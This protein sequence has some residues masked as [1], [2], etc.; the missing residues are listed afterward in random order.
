MSST[1][2]ETTSFTG[3]ARELAEHARRIARLELRLALAETRTTVRTFA[4]AAAAGTMALGLLVFGSAFL[5][6]AIAAAIALALPWWAALLI[7][8]GFLLGSAAVLAGLAVAL[9]RRASPPV[10]TAALEE[11][12]SVAAVVTRNGAG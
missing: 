10:P 6:A 12:R 11:A 8:A 9:V 4:F 5:L 7:V 3:A 1:T 2:G